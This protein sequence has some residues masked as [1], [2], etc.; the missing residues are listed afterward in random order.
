[1]A[2]PTNAA[3]KIQYQSHLLLLP[4]GQ[5]FAPDGSSTV[6]IYT[7]S[8]GP[9]RAWAPTITTYPKS[10]RPGS[11]YS[12][13]GTQLNGLSEAVS[14]GDDYAAATNYPIVR[15][16]NHATGHVF[17]ARTHDRNNLNIATDGTV[18]AT[19]FDAPANLELGVS[20]LVVIANGI[21]SDPVEINH[22]PVT[23]ASLSGTVGQNGWYRSDVQVTLAAVDPDGAADIV[24]TR[25]TVD[26]GST[27]TYAGP[28]IVSGDAIH[29]ITFWSEDQAG[30]Q[31]TPTNAQT[32]MIDAT[33]PTLSFLAPSPAANAA[34]WNNTAVDIAYTTGDNLSGV[35]SA[36]PGSP[37]HFGAEGSGQT[38]TVTVT[39][40]AGNSAT[41]TSPVVN[42][43]VTP[44][45]LTFG[46]QSPPANAFNWHN[47]PVDLAFSASDNLSGVAS[48]VP[49]SPLHF[50]AAGAG[51]TQSVTVT[52][53]A[54]NSATFT[55]P[56]INIDLTPPTL[57]A[58]PGV[59]SLWPPNHAM[60]PDAISGS[61]GD[62]LSGVDPSSMTFRVV[63]EYG[64]LQP[65][66]PVTVN[67]D[68]S[69]S[70]TIMLEASR[71]G[72]DADGRRYQIIVTA[73]DKSG[74][75]VTASTVVMVPHDQRER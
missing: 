74:N 31:D 12:L 6:Q 9:D 71:L 39:D 57:T 72:G 63:D 25:Y 48:A 4:S 73:T 38:M 66:G 52:D 40:E 23:T 44:P 35:L 65:T 32:I 58:S 33:P 8:G 53:A 69:Y 36:L 62:S 68:G 26:G 49:A 70:F 46:A 27:Q 37:L 28:I 18:I 17:W 21:P 3:S 34:G 29:Q 51:Q 30:N 22:P 13:S 67:A 50:G 42:I 41:F 56:A 2:R 75:R 43:D 55:S 15:I 1:V 14:Y 20:D 16:T 60:V 19:A 61:V 45:A 64:A 7:P 5:V 10:V 24:A 11:T 59:A 54:G 47:T